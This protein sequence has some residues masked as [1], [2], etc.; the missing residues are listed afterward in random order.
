MKIMYAIYPTVSFIAFLVADSA[1]GAPPPDPLP[2]YLYQLFTEA[3]PSSLP[4]ILSM[5]DRDAADGFVHLARAI[6][7]LPLAMKNYNYTVQLWALKL[8]YQWMIRNR[9]DVKWE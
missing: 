3:P 8:D 5:S 7:I 4:D 6:N 2:Y 9:Y 1:I